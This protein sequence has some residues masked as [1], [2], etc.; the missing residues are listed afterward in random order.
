M[1]Q[2]RQAFISKKCGM[3]D[4][5][6]VSAIG[7]MLKV[8]IKMVFSM[9]GFFLTEY[10][11]ALMVT[12]S[13]L[14]IYYLMRVG[15]AI[16]N[17]PVIC[18]HQ[19]LFGFGYSVAYR[20]GRLAITVQLLISLAWPH[21]LL[22]NVLPLSIVGGIYLLVLASLVVHRLART[23]LE[24]SDNRRSRQATGSREQLREGHSMNLDLSRQHL[25]PDPCLSPS[26][27]SPNHRS[28]WFILFSTAWMTM[29][30][31][32]L[33]IFLV[34][35]SCVDCTSHRTAITA[36]AGTLASIS[37][38]VSAVGLLGKRHL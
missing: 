27:P 19:L 14:G 1:R 4:K 15:M 9:V 20:I 21:G 16:S 7:W 35:S 36:M 18:Y 13:I 2:T 30:S 37:A 38:T 26:P 23:L 28:L 25:V 24:W 11:A 5:Q 32:S 6:I 33:A 22:I 29:V 34:M 12:A 31:L 10:W 3:T 8:T 17:K